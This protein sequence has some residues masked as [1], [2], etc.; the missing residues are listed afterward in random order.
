MGWE[1][2]RDL[3][4]GNVAFGLGKRSGEGA[5]RGACGRCPFTEGSRAVDVP[6]PKA[7]IPQPDYPTG[8]ASRG[9]PLWSESPVSPVPNHTFDPLDRVEVTCGRA[10]GR[11]WYWA[12]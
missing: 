2:E 9:M 11:H 6:V 7:V 1:E 3:T 5:L 8:T 12:L 10:L 4:P